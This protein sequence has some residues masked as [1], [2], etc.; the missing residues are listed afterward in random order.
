[1]TTQARHGWVKSAM[2]ALALFLLNLYIC[3]ELFTVEYLR[4]M[5]S[6]EGAFIGMSR[7]ITGHWSDL[8]W[9]PLWNNGTPF[10]TTYPALLHLMV[11]FVASV[12]G[13]TTAHAYHFVT[14]LGYCLGP[15]ALFALTLR[16]TGS[17]WAAFAAGLMYS[18][19]SMSAWLI[20]AIERDLG[21]PF[22]PRRLQALVYYGEG[23]HVSS[24]TLLT[25]ALLCL[26]LAMAKRRATYLGLAA[27]AL[28]ATATT[29]WL[30]AFA[31]ALVVVPYALAHLGPHGWKAR[32][33]MR[34]ALIG[35]A[36]Y[37]LAMPLM[38]PSTI[39]VLRMNAATT[40]GDYTGAYRSAAL[41]VPGILVALV[42]IKLALRKLAPHLQFAAL[43]AF[44]ITLITLADALWNVGIVPMA[45][46]YQLEME[47]ALTILIAFFG[48]RLLQFRP[49]RIAA[50]CVVGLIVALIQPIRMFRHYA[51]DFLLLSGDIHKTIEWKTADW[52]NRHWNDERVML[53]GSSAFWL[54][55]FSDIPQLWGF[56][57]AVTDHTIRDAEY[58]IAA[59][60]STN[61]KDPEA[62]VMWLKALGVH[63][64]GT[65]GP[66]SAEF[67]KPVVNPRKFEDALQPLWRFGK[68]D[69][70]YS[71]GRPASL[72]R[73]IPRLALV[74][75]TPI[76]GL[77]V[78][79]LRPFV[80]AL[81]DDRLPRADFRWTS[82]HSADISVK[83]EPEQL[84]SVQIAWS[85][86]WHATANGA[87]SPVL[88]DAIGLMYID[89]RISGICKI[90]MFYD[91]GFEMRASRWIFI[92]T[93]ALLCVSSAVSLSRGPRPSPSAG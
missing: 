88:R 9:F 44:L 91:G 61:P 38:P 47:L 49:P 85:N 56:D 46:R 76:H 71:V 5:G 32:D 20:P 25:I 60:P 78:D 19:L 64:V 33:W 28:A 65:S 67:Y 39:A 51:R 74:T 70:L 30:G 52:L 45:F 7:Y 63:A 90:Q 75:R 72:A 83:L 11:A 35:I 89:P 54:A 18:S 73:V 59:T 93:A 80:V 40:G 81:D 29:N 69:T 37:C 4:F 24:M 50:F 43:F 84:L 82:A 55:A 13:V 31:T 79:P 34:L 6:I 62:S 3:H 12:C 86:G 77:D 41:W 8:M 23:P 17:R 27:A 21:S 15:I 42:A 16:M 68:D 2:L 14:A 87:P 66:T 53:P 1:M 92:L 10:P 36:A 58:A 22:F 48:H 26:D 57:Q